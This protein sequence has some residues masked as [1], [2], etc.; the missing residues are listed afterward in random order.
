MTSKTFA[1]GTVI[2]AAWLNDVN[3]ATYTQVPALSA[4]ISAKA[5]AGANSDITSL[6]ALASVNGGQLAGMRNRIINGEMKISQRGL[7]FTAPST[8]SY[9]LDRWMVVW[10]GA[11]PSVSQALYA[12]SATDG[13]KNVLTI[14]G[15]AS[16]TAA[17]IMQRIESYNCSDLV[18]K[19]VTISARLQ[20]F[21]LT[22]VGWILYYANGADDW[23]AYTAIS[24]GTWTVSAAA[25]TVTATI[26]TL[27]T[28]A[29]RGLMLA[30]SPNN[31]AAFT[32]GS[33]SITAVQLEVGSV[34][35]PFEQRPYGLELS[36]CQR[37]Y[38]YVNYNYI[39]YGAA[40]SA[41]GGTVKVTA[42]RINAF[43][44]QQYIN[45]I[46]YTQFN[47][48]STSSSYIQV[49]N[50]AFYI[51]RTVTALGSAAFSETLLCTAEL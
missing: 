37:Y 1:S 41:V 42:K 2:D 32:T 10:T 44:I 16:N 35:T 26:A 15:V 8:L 50:E 23:T 34:A 51:S 7:T 21:G 18:N 12:G 20:A 28:T 40:G 19:T 3:A 47:V 4:S 17:Y 43:T 27:P 36:L 45:N 39:G 5:A 30:I 11:A 25:S 22:S 38:E 9:T 24:N 14:T 29:A 49:T 33:L 48:T 6:T 13:Y 31:Q 46:L